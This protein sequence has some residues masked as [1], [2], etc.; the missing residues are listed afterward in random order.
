MKDMNCKK[1]N[2]TDNEPETER[3]LIENHVDDIF[4]AVSSEPDSLLRKVSNPQR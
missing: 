2:K 1:I 4:C 3:Q